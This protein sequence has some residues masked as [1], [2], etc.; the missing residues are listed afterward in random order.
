[1]SVNQGSQLDPRDRLLQAVAAY[2]VVLLPPAAL[3]VPQSDGTDATLP[4]GALRNCAAGSNVQ[5]LSAAGSGRPSGSRNLACDSL[6]ST[7]LLPSRLVLPGPDEEPPRGCSCWPAL[8]LL[9]SAEPA[10]SGRV[11][12]ERDHFPWSVWQL[13]CQRDMRG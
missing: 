11:D 1:M 13:V 6:D 7:D 5:L 3:P 10:V 9:L 12:K 8:T 2:F 4:P